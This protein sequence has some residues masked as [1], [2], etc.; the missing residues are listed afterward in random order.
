[1]DGVTAAATAGGSCP[2]HESSMRLCLAREGPHAGGRRKERS[3]RG[4]G[5]R[6]D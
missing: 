4:E 1:V 6:R 3:G 5:R 2:T